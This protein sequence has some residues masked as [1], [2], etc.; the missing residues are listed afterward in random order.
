MEKTLLLE[1][2]LQKAKR[3]HGDDYDYSKVEYVNNKTKILVK[4]NK[5]GLEFEVRPDNHLNKKSGCPKCN[6]Q[7][8]FKKKTMDFIKELKEIYGDKYDYS[9][10][11]Y[12]NNKTKVCIIC[13]KH[14]EF[15][16]TPSHLLHGISCTKCSNNY[17]PTKDEL[18]MI[19]KK[20]YPTYDFNLSNYKKTKDVICVIDENKCEHFVSIPTLLKK[21]WKRGHVTSTSYL[22]YK[23]REKFRDDYDY[24]LVKFINR[25]TPIKLI[26]NNTREIVEHPYY[27][28]FQA[29]KVVEKIKT[30]NTSESIIDK[31]KEV[32]GDKYDYSKV[33]YANPNTKI[34]IICPIHGEFEIYPYNFLKGNGCP[35]CRKEEINKISSL[36]IENFLQK[37]REVHG[38]KYDYSKVEYVNNRTKVC[39]IC[40]THG[41]FWQT[42]SEHLQNH[43]CPVCKQS[44]LEKAMRLFL[45]K[46]N[47]VF[48]QQKHFEWLGLQSL[49]FY[50]PSK[51]LGIEC[52]GKQHFGLGDFGS[53]RFNKSIAQERDECKRKL[54][55]ENGV[56]LLYYSNLGIE[57]PYKVFENKEELL[58]EIDKNEL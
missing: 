49:D 22:I 20:K 34:T 41:E 52:Q 55:E 58:K 16:Q 48:E 26:N 4:C 19:L 56:K 23:L 14:G 44:K 27:Y 45:Q 42:P 15:W 18:L 51:K 10:V 40:P 6:K 54:C 8:P 38:D 32:Y 47:I 7:S 36:G 37:A 39:I 30:K 3:V 2:F 46:N 50:I 25:E 43:G 35:K 31:I 5:C 17:R 11:E 33:K 12:I 29:N 24:S 28:F 21:N 53:K 1:N 57:Y 13:P 9:K